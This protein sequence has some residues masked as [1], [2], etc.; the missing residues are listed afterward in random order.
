MLT[1]QK[2]KWGS[3]IYFCFPFIVATWRRLYWIYYK[4]IFSIEL[5]IKSTR[6]H[7]QRNII[8]LSFTHHAVDR[9]LILHIVSYFCSSSFYKYWSLKLDTSYLQN[10]FLVK[11]KNAGCR[12]VSIHNSQFCVWVGNLKLDYRY[13]DFV[14]HCQ[15]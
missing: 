15:I 9:G 5:V 11:H 14:P 6:T 10:V 1:K 8:L 13:Y 2:E 12:N 4:D 7:I 3:F